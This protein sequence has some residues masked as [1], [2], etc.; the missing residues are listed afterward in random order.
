[1]SSPIVGK[2][3]NTLRFPLQFNPIVYRL[4]LRI[5]TKK[6]AYKVAK[7][8]QIDNYTSRHTNK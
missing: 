1:M 4:P 6:H 5:I 3:S 8:I 7:T 2:R